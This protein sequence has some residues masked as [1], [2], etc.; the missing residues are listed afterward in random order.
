MPFYDFSKDLPVAQKTEKQVA[1]ILEKLYRAKILDFEDTYKYDI[2]ASLNG[3]NFTVEV[4]EDFTCEFT[5]NV[6]LE[7]SCRGHDSGIRTTEATYY[8]Y[9]IHTKSD[10]IQFVVHTTKAIKK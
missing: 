5:G 6:G 10:G 9:K 2:L 4:K 3:K 8:I 7:F 1:R